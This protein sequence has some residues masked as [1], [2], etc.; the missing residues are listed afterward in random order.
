MRRWWSR[1]VV[2]LTLLR[3]RDYVPQKKAPHKA[4]LRSIGRT[5]GC[6]VFLRMLLE[7]N[8]S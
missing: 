1:M 6:P 2:P 4:G 3:I 5:K 8:G 7:Q